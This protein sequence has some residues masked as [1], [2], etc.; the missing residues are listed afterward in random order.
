MD[1]STRLTRALN[2]IF[3]ALCAAA[4]LALAVIF[5]TTDCAAAAP[6][7]ICAALC[8]AVFAFHRFAVPRLERVSAKK[9]CAAFYI[10][11]AL[12]LAL[13]LVSASRSLPVPR[14]DYEAIHTGVKEAVELGRLTDSNPYFLRYA[15]QRGTLMVLSLYF[16]VLQRLGICATVNVLAGV[17]LVR[18]GAALACSLAFD[19]ARRVWGAPRALTAVLLMLISPALFTVASYYSISLGIPLAALAVWLYVVARQYEGAAINKAALYSL[20]GGALAVAGIISGTVNVLVAAVVIHLFLTSGGF[21]AFLKRLAALGVGFAIL[22]AGFQAV[23]RYGGIIDFA[24]EQKELLPMGYW[25][26]VAL[27]DDGLYNEDDYQ[28]IVSLP[29]Y[30]ARVEYTSGEIKRLLSESSPADL[31]GLAVRKTRLTWTSSGYA[32]YIKPG[33]AAAYRAAYGSALALL[34]LA[35]AI[36]SLKRGPGARTLWLLLCFGLIFFFCLW[37]AKP[38]AAVTLLPELCVFG[39]FALDKPGAEKTA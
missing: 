2:K 13:S 5:I 8:A 36:T 25:F 7:L 1:G 21:K 35:G 18:F 9:L 38:G 31:I 4:T 22:F 11:L 24:D 28:H 14:G 20:C 26:M 6:A 32:G 37:E 17:V 19:A 10:A 15:H 3:L 34:W 33:V 16:Y 39:A 29:D 12:W 30:G 27:K 23:I